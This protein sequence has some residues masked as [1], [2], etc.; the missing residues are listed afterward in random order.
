MDLTKLKHLIGP[1]LP[2]IYLTDSASTMNDAK[3]YPAPVLIV[4]A[5]Q[6][7][8]HGR[9]KRA[10]FAQKE[11]GIYLS[12]KIKGVTSDDAAVSTAVSAAAAPLY[13]EIAAVALCEAIE[14]LTELRPGIKWVNDLYLN[15][16]KV[17]G[18]LAQAQ[19]FAHAPTIETLTL[20]IGLNFD[21]A[22]ADFPLDLQDK[23]TSLFALGKA[24]TT[25]ED[26]VATFIA[27]FFANL[28]L[29]NAEIIRRYKKRLFFLG[30]P[31]SYEQ[32]GRTFEG[33]AVDVGLD[34]SL[35]VALVDGT[36][37]H[38]HSGEISLKKF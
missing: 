15:G 1:D 24:T 31:V 23:V 2:V 19:F 9:F 11:H 14:N 35:V 16:K 6:K 26:L 7:S 21:I 33:T 12:L 34:G 20:G 18:I 4:A 3:N 22:Q 13:T 36:R 32:N 10:F 27:H 28:N 38:L 29:A 30:R 8:A 25:P 37:Q 5:D 17:A